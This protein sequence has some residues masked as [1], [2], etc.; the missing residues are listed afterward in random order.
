V[1]RPDFY[2][3]FGWLDH[4]TLA[5]FDQDTLGLLDRKTIGRLKE[6]N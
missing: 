1:S 4:T 3:K 6:I 2:P 5:T